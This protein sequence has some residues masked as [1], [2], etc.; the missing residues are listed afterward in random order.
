MSALRRRVTPC[1]WVLALAGSPAPAC[2]GSSVLEAV[3]VRDALV[4]PARLAVGHARPRPREVSGLARDGSRGLWWT[5]GDRGLLV[6]WQVDFAAGRM[7]ARATVALPLQGQPNA[8]SVELLPAAGAREPGEL[9]VLDEAAARWWLREVVLEAS[10]AEGSRCEA[11]AV[12]L[13]SPALGGHDKLEGLACRDDGHCLAVS[14]D[15]RPPQP[16][17]LLLWLQLHRRGAR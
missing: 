14:D 8:G 16:R 10:C 5:V 4:L 1:A 15:G 7:E 6:G 2:P 13:A 12:P 3:A 9:A 17:T 11:P